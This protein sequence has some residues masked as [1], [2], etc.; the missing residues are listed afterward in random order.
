MNPEGPDIAKQGMIATLRMAQEPSPID[1]R[2]APTIIPVDIV[3]CQPNTGLLPV[4]TGYSTQFAFIQTNNGGAGAGLSLAA[5]ESG[6][7]DVFIEVDG[8]TGLAADATIW[9]G[10]ESAVPGWVLLRQQRLLNQTAPVFWRFAA[11]IDGGHHWRVESEAAWVG[12]IN[13]MIT[14]IARSL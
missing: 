4:I 9:M 12:D 2:Y 11:Y 10:I 14:A 7:Y 5:V 1:Y 8:G 3:S 6:I 13:F